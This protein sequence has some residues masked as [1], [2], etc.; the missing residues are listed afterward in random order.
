MR[1]R[2]H[3]DGFNLHYGGKRLAARHSG[4]KVLTWKWLDLR[5]L[6]SRIIERRWMGRGAV[7]DHVTSC[8]AR[9]VGDPGNHARQAAYLRAPEVSG[10]V[11]RIEFGLFKERS[12]ELPRATRGPDGGPVLAGK[13]LQTVG[14]SIREERARM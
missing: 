14:V 3:V 4:G 6:A 11:D 2:V 5:A 7:V 13:R 8:T 1:V 12:R 10:T 9:V